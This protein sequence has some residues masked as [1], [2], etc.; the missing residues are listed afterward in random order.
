LGIV[1]LFVVTIFTPAVISYDEPEEQEDEFLENLNYDSYHV[2]EITGSE[3]KNTYTIDIEQSSVSKSAKNL[4]IN[5]P[6]RP[7]NLGLMDSAWPMFCHDVRHTGRSPYNPVEYPIEKW[8]YDITYGGYGSPAIDANG[9]IYFGGFYFY[10]IYP[11]GSLKWRSDDFISIDSCPAIDEDGIIYVGN[12]DGGNSLYAFYPNGTTKWIREYGQIYS[13]PVI[14]QDGTIY[15]GRQSGDEGAIIAVYPN[16]GSLKWIFNTN[17]VVYSSPAIGDDG[18]IYCGS[19]DGN[20]Y[21]LYPNNGT[22]KWRYH[23]DHWIR[24]SP[25]IA[26]DGTIYVVS[27]DSYLHAVYP[28]NGTLKWKTNVGAGTS[29]TIGQDGTIYCGYTNLYAVNPNGT[30]KWSFDLGSGRKIRGSTPCNDANGTIFFGTSIN[31]LQGGEIIAVTS[32]GIER[33]RKLISNTYIEGGSCI[34][35]DGTLYIVSDDYNGDGQACYLNCFGTVESNNPPEMQNL[36][37]AVEGE[38]NVHYKYIFSAVDPDNN[39]VAYFVDWGDDTTSGWTMDYASG[40]SAFLWNSWSEEGDYTIKVKARDS[41]GEESDWAYLEVTMP[42]NQQTTHPLLELFKDRF[43]FLYQIL[44][45]VLE[46]LSI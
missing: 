3:F 28:I 35:E 22:E 40:V 6:T 21:A 1:L 5:E 24:T 4:E 42:V 34:A 19:H 7:V 31:D 18:T 11:N 41:P 13:S 37:G 25:C 23:T 26:D 14:G 9:I 16:N 27:L 12:S 33:W 15:F 44:F 30:I 8:R 43:P 17:H 29:P 2:S 45:R 36:E 32:D 38:I 46:E 39:P 10:A 20:L